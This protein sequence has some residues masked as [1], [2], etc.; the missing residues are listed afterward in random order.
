MKN[1]IGVLHVADKFGV[2]GSSVHG[3]SRLFSWWFPRFDESKF[4][5]ELVG[6][7]GPSQASKNLEEKGVEVKNLGRG[8]FDMLTCRDIYNEVKRGD[9]DIL[10]LHGYGSSNFG[11]LA[12]L[13]CD[14]VGLVR[15]VNR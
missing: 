2:G 10:H 8:K 7:R 5:V 13:F 3:V 14:T 9:F 15:H 11:I 1:K 12:S 6:L 4:N